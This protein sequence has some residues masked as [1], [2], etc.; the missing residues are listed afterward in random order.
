M[1]AI[2]SL[3]AERP[4]PVR[5]GA[6]TWTRSAWRQY[7][8]ERRMFWRN[9]TAAFFSPSTRTSSVRTE[10]TAFLLEGSE[11]VRGAARGVPPPDLLCALFGCTI[12]QILR[13]T[14]HG[15]NSAGLDGR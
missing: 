7:R 5:T 2:E 15:A 6:G 3:R 11:Y 14:C 9:P 4:A 8:L 12:E 10:K 1:T 13:R